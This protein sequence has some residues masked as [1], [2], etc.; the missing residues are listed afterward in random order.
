LKPGATVAQADAEIKVLGAQ[1]AKQ[2][3]DNYDGVSRRAVEMSR[4]VTP[5]VMRSFIITLAF[6]AGF[7]LLIVCANIA[8]LLLARGA[9]RQREMAVRTAM[10]AGRGRLVRQLLTESLLL[11]VVAGG[12][13]LLVAAWSLDFIKGGIPPTTTRWIPG[14]SN[15]GVDRAVLLFTLGLAVL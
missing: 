15:I 12:L 14:W 13:A 2:Y 10:G 11:A 8:N 5:D 7:V 1:L 6:A 4:G 3:P 9:T